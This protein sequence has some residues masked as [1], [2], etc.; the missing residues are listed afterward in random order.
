VHAFLLV[1]DDDAIAVA[2]RVA[3]EEAYIPAIVDRVSNG[4]QAMEYL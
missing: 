3:V 1:E 2:F 4:E